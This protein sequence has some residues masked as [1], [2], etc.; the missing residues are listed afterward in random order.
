[1]TEYRAGHVKHNADLDE[2][3]IRTIFPLDQGPN[4]AGMAWLVAS[5]AIGARNVKMEDIDGVEGW[6]DVYE[7]PLPPPLTPDII[8]PPNA[9]QA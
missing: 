6:E 7:P 9:T 1:M 8:P 5:K 2:V 3:A 4:M